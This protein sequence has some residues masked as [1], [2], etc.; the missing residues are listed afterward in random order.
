MSNRWKNSIMSI[1][2]VALAA[3]GWML[4]D[5]TAQAD[6]LPLA[7]PPPVC[8]KSFKVNGAGGN[9]FS[10]TS[11]VFKCS[12][13]GFSLLLPKIANSRANHVCAKPAG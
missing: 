9:A 13:G 8:A 1:A 6:D 3:G 7:G 10:C 2:A 5:M 4:G 11:D 12:A